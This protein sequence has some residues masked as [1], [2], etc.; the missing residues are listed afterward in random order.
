[1]PFPQSSGFNLNREKVIVPTELHGDYNIVL[2]AFQQWQQRH[3]DTWIPFA[4]KLEDDFPGVAHYEFP[5][6][7]KMN[8]ISRTFINE[9]MRAGIPDLVARERTITLYVDKRAFRR[10]LGLTNEDDIHVLLIDR[11]GTVLWQEFGR[12][13]DDKATSLHNAVL[14]IAGHLEPIR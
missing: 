12:I 10:S 7:R 9:G 3:I 6:I 14:R 1:M 4:R 13:T 5:I 8:V 2:I 11:D